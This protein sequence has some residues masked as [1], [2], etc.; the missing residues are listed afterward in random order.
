MNDAIPDPKTVG[1]LGALFISAFGFLYHRGSK[2]R[3]VVGRLETDVAALKTNHDNLN[4]AVKR[5]D[6][7][8][9]M[10]L[11]HLLGQK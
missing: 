2:V 7:N 1:G 9:Q 5:I 11:N 4:E 8:T 6:G 10:I 3:V